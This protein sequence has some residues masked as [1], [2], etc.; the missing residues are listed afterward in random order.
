M[1]ILLIST[2]RLK[3][4]MPPMPVGLAYIA[5]NIDER[6]HELKLLDLMF[7]KSPLE[8]IRR[9]IKEFQPEIIGVS[10]RNLDNQDARHTENKGLDRQKDLARKSKKSFFDLQA[11]YIPH[12]RNA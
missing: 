2:N 12:L 1:K 11:P 3:K 7:A 5:S 6:S 4:I 8:E 10:I 9:V